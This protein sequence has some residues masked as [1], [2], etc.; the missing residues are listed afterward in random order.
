[1]ALWLVLGVAILLLSFGAASVPL[2]DP[3]EAR[4]ARTSLEMLRRA[5]PVVPHFEDHPRL[6]KPPLLHWIQSTLFAALGTAEWVARLPTILATLGSILLVGWVA[7]RRFGIEGAAWAMAVLATTPL[8]VVI[9]RLGTLDALLALHVFAVVALDLAAAEGQARFRAPVV[10]GLLGLAFLIKGPVGVVVPLLIVLAGRTASRRDVWSGWTAL[11]QGLAGWC[12]VVLPWGLALIRRVGLDEVGAVVRGEALE[13]FFA[14][15][16]HVHPFWFYGVVLLVG[17]FPW[18]GPLLLAL[19][20]LLADPA[21]R[22]ARY[23]AAGLVVGLVFFSLS[24]SKLP[25]YILPLAPLAAIVVVWQLDRELRSP[26]RGVNGSALLGGTL[27]A[28]AIVFAIAAGTRLEGEPGRVAVIAA[29]IHALGALATLPGLW[30]RRPR[31]VYGAAAATSA[32]FLFVVV[33]L[34]LPDIAR[35]RTSAYLIREVP[36][37]AESDRPLLMVEMKVPSL[38][39]YLDRIPEEVGA[40][41]LESRLAAADDPVLVFDEADLPA[42]SA[43]TRGRLREIGRQGKYVVFVERRPGPGGGD[44]DAHWGPL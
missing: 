28:L 35:T 16:T 10:G 42:V 14:G 43:A 9:G 34:L 44:L 6:V 37:L 26:R 11:A 1:M 13:R 2:L 21:A 40:A 30:R 39:W 25:N 12:V 38:T 15:T 7:R 17:F 8:A 4:F 22:T 24:R 36:A 33:A 27:A 32:A 29:V 5:D 31:W 3:D 19:P 20:R 18:V 41:D 23:A